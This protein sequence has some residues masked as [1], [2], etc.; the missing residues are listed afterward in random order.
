MTEI[1]NVSLTNINILQMELKGAM[2]VMETK[3]IANPVA[4]DNEVSQAESVKFVSQ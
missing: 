3:Q 1:M 2:T 4:F